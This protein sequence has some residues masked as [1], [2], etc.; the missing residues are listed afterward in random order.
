M[1]QADH[2][3][4]VGVDVGVGAETSEGEVNLLPP[5]A[6]T[7]NGLHWTR[8]ASPVQPVGKHISDRDS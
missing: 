2:Q 8:S 5:L 4:S 7:V 6:D 3:S 1:V